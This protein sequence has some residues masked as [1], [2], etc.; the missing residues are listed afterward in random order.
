MVTIFVKTLQGNI[1]PF[2]IHE[3][4]IKDGF[5]CFV[6]PKTKESKRFAVSNCEI[7]EVV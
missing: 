1:I 2:R 6:D 4:E 3:Y 5:V 7:V